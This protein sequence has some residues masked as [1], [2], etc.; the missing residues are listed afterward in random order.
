MRRLLYI[1]LTPALLAF[2]LMLAS[3]P[4]YAA[5]QAPRHVSAPLLPL[6]APY[7]I[8]Q[9]HVAPIVI[10]PGTPART[11]AACMSGEQLVGGGYT[12]D[13]GNVFPTDN[14]PISLT[15]WLVQAFNS[16]P[17][18]IQVT[19]FAD[20]LQAP[21]SAG[22]VIVNGPTVAV[23]P[24][25]AATSV[26]TCPAGATV[27]GGGWSMDISAPT[28]RVFFSLP[29]SSFNAWGVAIVATSGSINARS[30]ALCSTL[31]LTGNSIV[32]N[33]LTIPPLSNAV[34]SVSCPAGTHLSSGGFRIAPGQN[35]IPVWDSPEKPLSPSGTPVVQWLNQDANLTAATV[36]TVDVAECLNP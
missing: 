33:P 30:V 28:G 9:R 12:V 10:A 13:G 7:Q 27:T 2:T 18:P 6:L 29:S 15:A 32:S 16:T 19:A 26:A 8:V 1:L 3:A 5:T 22:E 34:T 21:F 23:V 4:A 20:C 31:N 14:R 25:N 24:P 11:I 17:A 36:T 35:V